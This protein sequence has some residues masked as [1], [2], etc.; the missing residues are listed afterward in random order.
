[1]STMKEDESDSLV[2]L[3]NLQVII[4]WRALLLIRQGGTHNWIHILFI[5]IWIR[6]RIFYLW[7]FGENIIRFFRIKKCIKKISFRILV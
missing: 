7:N 5:Q 4:F 1:M 2:F 3:A 6:I